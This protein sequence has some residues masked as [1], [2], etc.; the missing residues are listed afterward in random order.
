MVLEKK[1]GKFVR[2]LIL[3]GTSLLEGQTVIL[4]TG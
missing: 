1:V 4:D 3:R 2:R